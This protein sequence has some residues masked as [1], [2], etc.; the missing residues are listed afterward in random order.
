MESNDPRMQGRGLAIAHRTS[1]H[2]VAVPR[3]LIPCR[4]GVE[5]PQEELCLLSRYLLSAFRLLRA[6]F[7][8]AWESILDGFGVSIE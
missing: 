4:I 3:A 7:A 8:L 6:L 5:G 2:Y 1:R